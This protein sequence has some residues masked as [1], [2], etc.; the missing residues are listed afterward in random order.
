MVVMKNNER[1]SIAADTR[2][3]LVVDDH[4]LIRKALMQLITQESQNFSCIE[5]EN[6]E[7]ALKILKQ[8]K[9]DLAILDISMNKM[10]GLQLTEKMQK[11]YPDTHVII[12]SMHDS[13]FYIKR[14]LHAGAKGYLVKSEAAE[15]IIIAIQTVLDGQTYICDK[16]AKN[17]KLKK[18]LL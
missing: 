4:P 16:I 10:S 2:N 12:L 17:A 7:T 11:L 5:A 13:Y 3:I 18:H 8:Q 9:F 14:A 15:N 1:L 6:A